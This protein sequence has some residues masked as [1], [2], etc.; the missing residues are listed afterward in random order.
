MSESTIQTLKEVLSAFNERVP[1]LE[2]VH[3][4]IS[5]GDFSVVLIFVRYG[6]E[7]KFANAHDALT[8]FMGYKDGFDGVR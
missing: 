1:L 4:E 7:R 2:E 3:S 6:Q 8:Y 5:D